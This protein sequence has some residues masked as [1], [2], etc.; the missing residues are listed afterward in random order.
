VTLA[1]SFGCRKLV[2]IESYLS[3]V[4]RRTQKEILNNSV[5]V[6]TQGIQKRGWCTPKSPI[7]SYR[8]MA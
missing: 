5:T 7:T 8:E 1:K 4:L 6:P 3:H 2:K